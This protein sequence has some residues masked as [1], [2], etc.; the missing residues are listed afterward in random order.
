MTNYIV[1]YLEA[2]AEK[3]KVIEEKNKKI[4]NKSILLAYRGEPK[5]YGA[6]KLMPSLFRNPEFITREKYLFELLGDYNVVGFEKSRYIEKAIEAQ[7]YVSISRALDIAFSVLP[8]LFFACQSNENENGVLYVFG[9][10]KHFSPHSKYIEDVYKNILEDGKS[11]YDK[12]FRVMTH[13]KYNERIMAQSGGFIFFPGKKHCPINKLYYEE[14]PINKDHKKYILQELQDYFDVD[15]AKLFPE[16]NNDAKTVKNIFAEAKVQDDKN[17]INIENEIDYFFERVDYET[18]MMRVTE[19]LSDEKFMR[20][21]RKEKEDLLFFL[22]R[23]EEEEINS[24]SKEEVEKIN[25]RYM[26]FRANI[27]KRFERLR[28]S[29]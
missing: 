10:P 9:F 5:D 18:E 23:L 2:I 28:R 7:H 13:S 27:E 6:T 17:V 14:I 12:N 4:N 19:S 1:Q 26:M 20:I 3:V 24:V 29:K 22:R 16:K 8:A 15:E 11:V 25:K 21:L